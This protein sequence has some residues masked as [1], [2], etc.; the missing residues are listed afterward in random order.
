MVLLNFPKNLE[1]LVHLTFLIQKL[2]V[3]IRTKTFIQSPIVGEQDLVI[4]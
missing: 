4:I 3:I 2:M 1:L